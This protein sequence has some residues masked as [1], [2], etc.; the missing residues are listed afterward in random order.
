M[1]LFFWCKAQQNA[2]EELKK[3]LTEEPLLVLPN[4]ANFFEIECDASHLRISGVLMQDGKPVAYH[5]EKLDDAL[6]N[7]TIYD[8]E[9]YA[10]FVF[11]KFGNTIFGQKSLL[12]IRIMNL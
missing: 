5:S 2:F 6:L 12:S 4:F 11:L 10:L 3:R 9:L 7:Y 1:F 8:K